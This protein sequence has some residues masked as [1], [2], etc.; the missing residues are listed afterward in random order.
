M[1]TS[2][3][4]TAAVLAAVTLAAAAGTA[5]TLAA[6]A[7]TATTL[8]AAAG[9]ATTVAATAGT[10]TTYPV[11]TSG[12]VEHVVVRYDQRG[13]SEAA[14]AVT[15]L[16]G[17]VQRRLAAVGQLTAD[18]PRTTLAALRAAPGVAA[19]TEDG[20]VRLA[21]DKWRADGTPTSMYGIEAGAGVPGVWSTSDAAGQKVTGKGVGVALIDSGIAPVAG[22][23][24][25]GKVVNGPDLSFE[26]QTPSL[27]YLDTFGH[28][29]HMA[30][31]IAGRDAGVKDGQLADKTTFSGIA[32]G[33]TLINMKVAAA[34]GA[35]DVSQVIA[36]I[37]WVVEHR[38]DPGL[39]IR[40]LNLSFGTDSVQ[41]ERLD[42]LSYAVEAAWRNGIVV[43]V[44]AGND[45]SPVRLDMPAA[46]PYV[47]AVGAADPNGT[48]ARADDTVSDFSNRGT[49]TRHADL[50]AAGRSVVSLRNPGS[51]VDVNYPTGLVSGDKDRRFF[52]G[53]G[54]SQ[55]TA[56]VSGAVALLVQQRPN[57]SPDQVKRLLMTTA[58]AMPAADAL[59]RGAGQLNVGAAVRAPAPVYQQTFP[60]ATGTGSL[61]LSRGTSHVADPT[62][63]VELRGERD[64]MGQSWTPATWAPAALAGRTWSGGIWNGSTWTGGTWSGASWAGR[65]WADAAWTGRTWTGRTWT[66]A[67]WDGRTWTGRTWTGRTWTGGTWAGTG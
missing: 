55:A 7:G 35:T 15:R 13:A 32:P 25:A 23:S 21:A 38:K 11:A 30:G 34:D 43:V 44:S 58:D 14:N 17:H 5:T 46:N 63:G 64:I 24:D 67:G 22:L 26:S 3:G 20:R 12:P 65:T 2:S 29:T 54:T 27:R 6:A 18:V 19:V 57:L 60:A 28:G 31:I 10:A 37:D 16:G 33:A 36:A 47:I 39:N 9:T 61:E 53:S 52:R 1:R 8:A 51:Y 49:V 56:V 50:V 48:D 42:P 66:D 41:D 45:G 40:V 59:G 4:L 62:S